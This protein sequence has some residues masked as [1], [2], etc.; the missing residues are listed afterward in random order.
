MRNDDCKWRRW[1]GNF[2]R[3]TITLLVNSALRAISSKFSLVSRRYSRIS[4][5]DLANDRDYADEIEGQNGKREMK[6]HTK[7]KVSY[8]S[9]IK[10]FV[11]RSFCLMPW[12]NS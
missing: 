10:C 9:F 6:V 8:L 7:F 2:D 4:W 11:R 1:P 5:E 3:L 12:S